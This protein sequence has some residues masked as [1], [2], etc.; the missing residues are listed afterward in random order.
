M[1]LMPSWVFDEA[2]MKALGMP[3][4]VKWY[5][6]KSPL[7]GPVTVICEYYPNPDPSCLEELKTVLATYELRLVKSVE[8]KPP[9]L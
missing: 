7:D 9:A 4:G 1:T 6:I 3:G 2:V 5:V 8:K